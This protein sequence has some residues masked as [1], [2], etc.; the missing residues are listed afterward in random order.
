[1]VAL[2]LT[3]EIKRKQSGSNI[4]E[5]DNMFFYNNS[6]KFEFNKN[7]E[8][9]ISKESLKNLK[10]EKF[11]R[12]AHP[13]V[14]F[15]K[16]I[17]LI[18]SFL[19]AKNY[20]KTNNLLK[21]METAGEKKNEENGDVEDS[22]EELVNTLVELLCIGLNFTSNVVEA[23]RKKEFQKSIMKDE[24]L[25]YLHDAKILI[26]GRKES[27]LE[28]IALSND[29][30]EKPNVF[31]APLKK[32]KE[33]SKPEGGDENA[34]TDHFKKMKNILRRK[35]S[36][37]LNKQ[38]KLTS[39]HKQSNVFNFSSTQ[40]EKLSNIHE[41]VISE[42][43]EERVITPEMKNNN[44]N[45]VL[46]PDESFEYVEFSSMPQ[47]FSSPESK[48]KHLRY[49]HSYS[50]NFDNESESMDSFSYSDIADSESGVLNGEDSLNQSY[51]RLVIGIEQHDKPSFLKRGLLDDDISDD[52]LKNEN[53]K[54]IL[55]G[56]E[57]YTSS[58]SLNPIP[59][60][61]FSS[62][63]PLSADLSS[64]KIVL[65]PV[66]PPPKPP[67]PLLSSKHPKKIH[68]LPECA[69]IPTLLCIH[70]LSVLGQLLSS[71]HRLYVL[72]C[73]GS[74]CGDLALF[75]KTLIRKVIVEME[76][77]NAKE[78]HGKEKKNDS[79]LLSSRPN[80]EEDNSNLE[81]ERKFEQ[82]FKSI[83]AYLF[84]NIS[85]GEIKYN[86]IDEMKNFFLSEYKK[87]DFFH[88]FLLDVYCSGNSGESFLSFLPSDVFG[89]LDDSF[90]H[91]ISSISYSTSS[92]FSSL[93]ENKSLAALDSFKS[94]GFKKVSQ[95]S[96]KYIS[97]FFECSS[98][99]NQLTLLLWSFNC[100]YAI[101]NSC[102]ISESF[103]TSFNIIRSSL[104]PMYFLNI[105]ETLVFHHAVLQCCFNNC[106][107]S[108]IQVFSLA[109]C[110]SYFSPLLVILGN[111]EQLPLLVNIPKEDYYVLGGKN[112]VFINLNKYLNENQSNTAVVENCRINEINDFYSTNE[113][114][115]E[116]NLL[117]FCNSILEYFKFCKE[118]NSRRDKES[119]GGFS[120]KR[121][122]KKYGSEE[123][124]GD[125]FFEDVDNINDMKNKIKSEEM[126]RNTE[127][128]RINQDYVDKKGKM[129]EFEK[130]EFDK[131]IKE[132]N[133]KENQLSDR[134]NLPSSIP[135][136]LVKTG[137]S[138][139]ITSNIKQSSS[140]NEKSDNSDNISLG[141]NKDSES[142]FSFYSDFLKNLLTN[143]NSSVQK[144]S[145]DSTSNISAFI[146]KTTIVP[147][148]AEIAQL[149]IFV[150]KNFGYVFFFFFL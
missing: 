53:E 10:S 117:S 44:N 96:A 109:A 83:I 91:T 123:N 134:R 39:F 59:N 135:T 124:R 60:T 82:S 143:Y 42:I 136:P 131:K 45:A 122:L 69:D 6:I 89:Y 110:P 137:S 125:Y 147:S 2:L 95:Y 40:Q 107:E 54:N 14:L 61:M 85:S 98:P 101:F 29:N 114:I 24:N 141:N 30:Y 150:M 97:S 139:V 84:N 32:D 140:S 145:S 103:S 63:P 64:H 49:S 76:Y 111:F 25:K 120:Y 41:N 28:D 102:F 21:G 13:P 149:E 81:N 113:E 47:E 115:Y 19:K 12:F 50:Y 146:T 73:Y 92:P 93:K 86:E 4:F 90:I 35:L 132:K 58:K 70:S 75:A 36:S 20:G 15:L 37:S 72:L 16:R 80:F 88:L 27:T 121:I 57:N 56:K 3:K 23:N 62:I 22:G 106:F 78:N 8:D 79:D 144:I 65:P 9:I 17:S 87:R 11:D 100:I 94:K 18:H 5:E 119:S 128:Q 74:I 43:V 34:E 99:S 104:P 130:K 142:K 68:S 55:I 77:Y 118:I 148:V 1:V 112:D 26:S 31:T 126:N 51:D 138:S 108:I 33:S 38:R 52:D 67:S 129:K 127:K 105:S 71:S 66:A 7:N 133:K 46:K 48:K 116:I